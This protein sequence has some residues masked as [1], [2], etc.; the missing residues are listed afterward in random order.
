MLDRCARLAATSVPLADATGLVLDHDV[1][2]RED[3]P[4]FAN[5]AVDGYA[6]RAAD[7]AGASDDEP[8]V[9]DV[10]DEGAVLV[11]VRPWEIATIALDVGPA[12]LLERQ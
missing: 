5:S 2:A 4:P 11:P 1:V 9:L 6:V 7:V 8:I 12:P 10:I 3:V